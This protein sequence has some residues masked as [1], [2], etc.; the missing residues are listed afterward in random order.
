MS[1]NDSELLTFV[2]ANVA[3]DLFV[4]KAYTKSGLITSKSH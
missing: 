2:S 3:T 1:E 4:Y